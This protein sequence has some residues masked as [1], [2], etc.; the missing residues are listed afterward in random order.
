MYTSYGVPL[1]DLTFSGSQEVKSRVF[2]LLKPNLELHYSIG[3]RSNLFA[4]GTLG[5]SLINEIIVRDFPVV[6]L[7]GQE[8][9]VSHSTNLSYSALELGYSLHLKNSFD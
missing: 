1:Y 6:I 2:P 4:R 5:F 9:E 7:E 3:E 8:Y